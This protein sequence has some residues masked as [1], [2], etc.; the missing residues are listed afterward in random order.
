M[1]KLITLLLCIGIMLHGQSS[2]TI[3][4]STNDDGSVSDLVNNQE[5]ESNQ[6]ENVESPENSQPE[7]QSDR[8]L[9]LDFLKMIMALIVV[10]GLIYF[11]LK[12]LQKRSR[13]YQQSRSLENLGGLSLGANKSVQIVRVG[14]KYFLIGVGEDVQLLNEI[15]DE[16][17][18]QGLLN[19]QDNET[20][21]FQDVLKSLQKKNDKPIS[22]R[23]S[24]ESI[25]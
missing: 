25:Q 3:E 16:E 17:T 21:S 10:L 8:S 14:N 11:L 7:F 18:I 20:K 9:F 5:Q 1:K 19:H 2:I 23:K 13:I 12:F 24:K 15:D 22:T 4:A 6:S